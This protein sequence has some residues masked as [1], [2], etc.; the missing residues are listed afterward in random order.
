MTGKDKGGGKHA[1][2]KG[3]K[4]RGNPKVHAPGKRDADRL[5]KIA[6]GKDKGKGGKK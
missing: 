2:P 4:H 6:P 3:G 1:A 5:G